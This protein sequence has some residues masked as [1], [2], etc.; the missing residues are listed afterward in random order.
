MTRRCFLKKKQVHANEQKRE[1]LVQAR[2]VWKEKQKQPEEFPA[3]KLVFLDES[4]VNIDI[5]RR[6]RRVKNKNRVHNYVLR[7]TPKK[8]TLVSSVRLDGTQAY[9]F[10]QGSLNGENFL[11][12]V[13]NTLVPTLKKGDIVVTDNLSCHKVK[14]VREVIEQAGASVLYPPPYS[15]DLNPIEMMWSKMK[16]LLLKWETDTLQLLHASIPATFSAVST[17]NIFSWFA[18]FGYFLS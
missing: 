15:S 3:E 11:D 8:T 9:E 7:N 4:G 17:S 13:K 18:A 6:Y 2:E 16:S 14:G 12:Y 5:A 10:F 1:D